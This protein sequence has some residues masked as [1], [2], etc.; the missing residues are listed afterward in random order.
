MT[1]IFEVSDRYKEII[2][3]IHQLW[4]KN[5]DNDSK[6]TMKESLAANNITER[7]LSWY[8]ERLITMLP[9]FMPN[10]AEIINNIREHGKK[11]SL[12]VR[13]DK[14]DYIREYLRYNILMEIILR[15]DLI[16]PDLPYFYRYK[17]YKIIRNHLDSEWRRQV[18]ECLDGVNSGHL[19]VM[20]EDMRGRLTDDGYINT[21][22]SPVIKRQFA[23]YTLTNLRKK[24]ILTLEQWI[25]EY[26]DKIS[27]LAQR[28]VEIPDLSI[29]PPADEN[30]LPF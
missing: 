29:N 10:P 21:D 12:S 26:G 15:L 25:D 1:S 4:N 18:W 13:D 27:L 17:P 28:K 8:Y 7:Q 9:R 20:D 22:I 5:K 19:D 30:E 23:T 14:G 2:R 16:P 24:P 11:Q 3:D 6:T